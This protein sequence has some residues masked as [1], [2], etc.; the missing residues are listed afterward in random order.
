MPKKIATPSEK[1]ITIS[2]SLVVSW[3]VGQFTFFNSVYDSVKY[4]LIPMVFKNP[5]GAPPDST[6]VTL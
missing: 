2:V 5:V 4:D 3:R 6:L 1:P